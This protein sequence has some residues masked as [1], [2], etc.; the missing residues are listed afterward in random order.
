MLDGLF[1]VI[2]KL[3]VKNII[4]SRQGEISENYKRFEEIVRKKKT[5]LIIVNKGDKLH[6][7]KDFYIDIIWPNNSNFINENIL[8]N[9]SIVCQI[10]Y[11]K[12]SML[13]TGDIEEIAENEILKELKKETL[14][15]DILKVGH[16]GSK[17]SSTKAFIEAVSPKIAMIGVGLNNKFGHP[18]QGVLKRLEEINCKVYRTDIMGEICCVVDRKGNILRIT[19][20]ANQNYET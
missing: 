7:E 8:N 1:K 13:F 19:K 17:S 14:K 5:K 16:H 6:I 2:K 11:R 10:R 4:I 3:K 12:F 9:N 18:N 20:Y 15:S